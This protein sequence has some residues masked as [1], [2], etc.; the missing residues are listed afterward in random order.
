[1]AI[2]VFTISVHFVTFSFS[3]VMGKFRLARHRKH[4]RRLNF[5]PDQF[6]RDIPLSGISDSV[7]DSVDRLEY[8]LR[9]LNPFPSWSTLFQV[10][11]WKNESVI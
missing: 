7:V 3:K 11:H 9:I 5:Y 2:S 4:E 8:L 6:L 1:M 10:L